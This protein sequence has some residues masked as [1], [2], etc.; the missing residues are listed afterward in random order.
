MKTVT[1]QPHK[2]SLGMEANIAVVVMYIIMVV[3]SWIMYANFLSWAVPLVFFFIEKESRFVK[4]QSIQALG[5]GVVSAVISLL[6][7]IILW[8]SLWAGGLGALALVSAL[9]IIVG[10]AIT[11]L[12]V[13]IVYMAFNYKIVE[14]PVIGPIAKKASNQ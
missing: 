11:A 14:L 2:S 10:I 4:Y 1:V 6:L 8:S 5:I 9:S 7:Q 12:V 13:Y 3:L